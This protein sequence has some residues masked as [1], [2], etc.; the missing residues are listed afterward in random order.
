MFWT[1]ATTSLEDMPEFQC[2]LLRDGLHIGV[3]V[4]CGHVTN[5]RIRLMRILGRIVNGSTPSAFN[6]CIKEQFCGWQS[7]R[8]CTFDNTFQAG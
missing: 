8:T 3:K 5:S 7:C 1:S 4:P 2:A 6:E